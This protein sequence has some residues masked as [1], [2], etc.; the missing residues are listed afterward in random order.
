M[1]SF[2]YG[3]QQQQ[4]KRKTTTNNEKKIFK[5]RPTTHVQIECENL[6][7]NVLDSRNDD[8]YYVAQAVPL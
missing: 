8:D 1:F 3:Y 7:R 2:G 6:I 4:T 5:N